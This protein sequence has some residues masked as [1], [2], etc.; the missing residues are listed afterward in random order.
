MYQTKTLLT[1]CMLS[2]LAAN[3]PQTIPQPH[4]IAVQQTLQDA[5][6]KCQGDFVYLDIDDSI[7]H[8][9]ELPSNEFEEPPYFGREGLVGAHISVIYASEHPSCAVNQIN[10]LGK[11]ILIQPLKYQIVN[12]PNWKGVESVY[13]LTFESTEL[14]QIREKYGLNPKEHP[15]HLTLGIKRAL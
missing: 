6:L 3:E 14:D 15:Y 2:C 5:V 1:A 8:A 4:E 7:V 12:P 13:I 11:S 10:E 9:A